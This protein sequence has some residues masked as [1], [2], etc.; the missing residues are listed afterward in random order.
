MLTESEVM[1]RMVSAGALLEGHF[2]LRSGLHSDRYFQAA[3]LLQH[4]A[5]AAELAGDM[6]A[7]W[8]NAGIQ[9]IVSP[10]VGGIIV[11][12]EIGRILGVRAIFA[13]KDVDGVLTLRR[14][15]SLRPGELVLVAEDVVTKGGSVR[16][17]IELVKKAG[18]LPM[19]VTSIVDRSD[20][21]IDFGVPFKSL[22]KI[23]L[24]TFTPAECPLC[25]RGIPL[26]DPGRSR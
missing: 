12:Q 11:G 6:A 14:G 20:G 10:A 7:P 23:P 18:A 2:R 3:L 13:E 4:T 1:D 25:L 17:V 15:F 9:T 16:Q 21:T 26:E 5:I 8:R 24:E 19:G 22:L